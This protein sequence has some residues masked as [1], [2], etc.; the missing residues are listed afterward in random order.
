VERGLGST[1]GA[2]VLPI[3]TGLTA[4][5]GRNEVIEEGGVGGESRSRA[6]MVGVLRW[7][8]QLWKLRPEEERGAN[9]GCTSLYME[10]KDF[11]QL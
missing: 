9:D 11:D 8:R 1:R 7:C 10:C 4:S 3:A 2:A 6:E 5:D